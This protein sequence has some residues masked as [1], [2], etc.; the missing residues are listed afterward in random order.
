MTL[1]KIQQ[2]WFRSTKVDESESLQSTTDATA[3]DAFWRETLTPRGGQS[4]FLDPL[5]SPPSCALPLS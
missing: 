3:K 1:D 5:P 2:E 4:R